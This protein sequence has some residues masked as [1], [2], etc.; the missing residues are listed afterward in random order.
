[1]A[2]IDPWQ[3]LAECQ[4]ALQREKAL[5]ARALLTELRDMWIALANQSRFLTPAQLDTEV[6]AVGRVYGDVF[7]SRQT[8]S[9]LIDA[10][11]DFSA[12]RNQPSH[13]RSV[14]LRRRCSSWTAKRPRLFARLLP[15][16]GCIGRSAGAMNIMRRSDASDC[17]VK[18]YSG[19]PRGDFESFANSEPSRPRRVGLQNVFI[20]LER[21]WSC[22]VYPCFDSSDSAAPVRVLRPIGWLPFRSHRA[23]ARQGRRIRRAF[24]RRGHA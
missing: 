22:G 17:L 13:R 21:N 19:I 15:R 4:A 3:R 9:Q 14:A 20:F 24:H 23:E 6:E 10:R 11:P 18:P 12:S 1:M 7:P 8:V 16:R 2:N 5:Q